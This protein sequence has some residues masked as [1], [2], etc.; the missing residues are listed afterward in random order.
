VP[1]CGITPGLQVKSFKSFSGVGVRFG[2]G[3][4]CEDAHPLAENIQPI[5]GGLTTPFGELCSQTFHLPPLLEL[6]G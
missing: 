6:R 5:K 4:F 1:R 2:V 3:T